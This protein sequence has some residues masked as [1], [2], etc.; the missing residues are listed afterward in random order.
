VNVQITAP[1]EEE[2][3]AVSRKLS[4]GT[5]NGLLAQLGL[6]EAQVFRYAHEQI[7]IRQ[8]TQIS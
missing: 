5:I 6:P 7:Y 8:D 3:A 1:S 2:A 4:A